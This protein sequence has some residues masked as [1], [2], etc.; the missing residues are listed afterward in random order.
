MIIVVFLANLGLSIA[1]SIFA[2]WAF[3][4]AIGL[5]HH[6]WIPAC[7]TIGYW[8]AVGIAL[9]LRWAFVS[10]PSAGSDA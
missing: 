9:L 4:L 3:M 2:G 1:Y 8:P 7:P 10:L 5:V 6:E